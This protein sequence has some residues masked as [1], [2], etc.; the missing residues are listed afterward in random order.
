MSSRKPKKPQS[1]TGRS[2]QSSVT[3]NTP[4]A[5]SVPA[6]LVTSATASPTTSKSERT[7]KAHDY[8]GF[9]SSV[10]SVSDNDSAPAPKR[11]ES[12]NPVIET[13][14]QEEALQPHA[15]ETSFD[16]PV[17]SPSAPPPIGT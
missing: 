2:R 3:L 12:I 8:F 6:S 16:L 17:I 5:S 14:R 7:R 13:L 4:N 15:A 11:H 10:R 1:G 9:E